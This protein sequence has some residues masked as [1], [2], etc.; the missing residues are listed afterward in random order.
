MKKQLFKL[1]L[2]AIFLFVSK[3][4]VAQDGPNAP[5]GFTAIPSSTAYEIHLSWS[6]NSNNETR[7]IIYKEWVDEFVNSADIILSANATAYVDTEVQPNVAYHYSLWSENDFGTSV[8]VYANATV[9]VQTP[10]APTNFSVTTG[11]LTSIQVNFT[12][13]SDLETGYQI[14]HAADP[15]QSIFES[16]V[17]PG[18]T[19]GDVVTTFVKDYPHNFTVYVR[20][21]AFRNDNGTYI[22]GPFTPLLSATTDDYPAEPSNFNSVVEDNNI[23]LSWPDNATNE[24]AYILVRYTGDYNP[25]FHTAFRLPANTTTYLDSTAQEGVAYTYRL[26]AIDVYEDVPGHYFFTE[27]RFV[28]T[29]ATIYA[30]LP[31]PSNLHGG[32]YSP[33]D[34][35]FA[36]TDNSLNETGFEVFYSTIS[37]TG[38]FEIN[39]LEDEDPDYEI[40]LGGLHGFEPNTTVYFKVRAVLISPDY[41]DTLYSNFSNLASVETLPTDVPAA[42]LALLATYVTPTSFVAN[43]ESVEFGDHYELYVFSINDSIPLTGYNGIEVWGTSLAVSGNIN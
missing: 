18:D 4:L 19:M 29:S 30:A 9:S 28:E 3:S 8:E 5:S 2:P 41:M 26:Q 11:P 20:V 42:P 27:G 10:P 6:D 15:D 23:R 31:A 12:D 7:F 39:W 32:A 37:P 25:N 17:I 14:Q 16:Y 34:I 36:Y 38:P 22:Y 13:N 1:A 43:W 35:L 24:A 40:N 21:R 33:N